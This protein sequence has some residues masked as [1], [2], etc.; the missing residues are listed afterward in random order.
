MKKLIFKKLAKDVSLF[1]LISIVSISVIIWIIQAVNYL[2][3]VSEDGHSLKVYFLYTLYSFPKI[4]S[5]ILPFVFMI[6]LFYIILK[7]EINNELL[8]YWVNGISKLNFLNSVIIITL[9]YIL[10]QLILTLIVVP[11]TL[12]KGRS[13][14]RSSNTDMFSNVIKEKKFSDIIKNFT[15][16]VD[17][18]NQNIL[19]NIFIKEQLGE[20]KSQITIAETG[21]II[22]NELNK[23]LILRNGKIINNENKDQNIIDFS[24]FRINL[25]KYNTS[26]ITHQ[27]TQEMNTL[28]LVKCLIE[29]KN[30]QNLFEKNKIDKVFFKGCNSKISN[31]ILEEFLKRFF[32][33]IFLLLIGLSSSL[34]ILNNK[35]DHNA[36]IKNIS[37]FI[38][39]IFFIF[40]SEV[41]LRSS[42]KSINNILIYIIS[43]L[44]MSCLIY[45]LF[46]FNKFKLRN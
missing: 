31:A 17:D 36:K 1:F 16:Y 30:N 23:I 5:K 32:S 39:G 29:I 25:S 20:N 33:P 4:I 41:G 26:T 28:S 8:I 24:E 7:Y 15:I 6:A 2:D 11:Y 38:L 14:F 43:P 12:D 40:A 34:I 3:L 46:F 19:N 21:E 22:N 27:K 45:L 9:Y 18:K 44:F 42:G 37:I 10:F 35:N 13:F